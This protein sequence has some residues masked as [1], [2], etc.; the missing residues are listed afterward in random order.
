MKHTK[1]VD[2][3]MATKI[4][5]DAVRKIASK[6]PGVEESTSYGTPSLKVGGKLLTCLAINK[7]AEPN[8]LAVS[9]DFDQREGLLAD[10]PDTYYITDHYVDYPVVLVRL[11]RVS[12]DA[13][14]ELL[15]G[16]WR[17]RLCQ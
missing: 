11:S 8:S 3:R 15:L 5:F 17:I 9:I 6:L 1:S 10:A 7:S 16:A 2:R 14:R 13:L 4:T 12:I